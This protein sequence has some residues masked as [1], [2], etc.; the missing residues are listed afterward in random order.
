MKTSAASLRSSLQ[1]LGVYLP[2][3]RQ[4]KNKKSTHINYMKEVIKRDDP[5]PVN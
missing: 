2:N 5:I 4:S 3:H 1:H